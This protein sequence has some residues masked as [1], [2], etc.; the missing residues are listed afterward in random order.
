MRVLALTESVDHVCARYR[1]RAFAP[2]LAA[3]GSTLTIRGIERGVVARLRQ[4][5]DVGDYDVV[6]IQRKLLPGWQ[7]SL[8]RR[9]ARRLVFD[10]DDA[11]LYRDSNDSRGPRSPRR[12][13]R[14]Q[15]VVRAADLVVAGNPFLAEC[16]RDGGASPGRVEIIPTCIDV[17]R[18]P[19][20]QGLGAGNA[21]D[22]VWIGSS[23]TLAGLE[24]RTDLW[25]QIGREVPG[26][27]LRLICDRFVRFD[28]LNVTPVTWSEAT[29][30][31]ELARS[32]V[33]VSWLPDDLWSRGKCGLKVLQYQAAGLPVVANPV[34]VHP[35]MIVEGSTGYL[36]TSAD[37]WCEVIR[38][39]RDDPERRLAMGRAA[40]RR[41]EQD[42]SVATWSGKFVSAITGTS[43]HPGPH[44]SGGPRRPSKVRSP[45]A[46]SPEV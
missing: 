22:L 3:A 44:S 34:G 31:A 35:A 28:P 41:A 16:A 5:Q 39:L 8:V 23:S 6:V 26:A 38:S 36:P 42:Y 1:I 30:T 45:T 21:V 37:E 15:A 18:Y 13:R 10:F 24:A 29:E 40:R 9:R 43:R 4:L 19:A 2:A 14:F 7:L 12:L 32:D 20:R 33:G 27:S 25:Q 17:E 46:T 11:V